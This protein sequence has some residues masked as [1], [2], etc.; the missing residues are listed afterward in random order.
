MTLT[1]D[2]LTLKLLYDLHVTWA[3]FESISIRSRV[4][5]RHETD[6]Y[7]DTHVKQLVSKC[8]RRIWCDTNTE[9]VAQENIADVVVL[10]TFRL[11][12][13]ATSAQHLQ[14]FFIHVLLC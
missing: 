6:G 9:K 13:S 12:S 7:T 14:S 11:S 10:Q 3:T 8:R 1:V 2:V 5:S 4:R